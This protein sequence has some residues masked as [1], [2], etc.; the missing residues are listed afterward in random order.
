MT[1]LHDA[2]ATD[3]MSGIMHRGV[4]AESVV[5]FDGADDAV[6]TVNIEDDDA[7]AAIVMSESMLAL[8]EEGTA[9]YTVRP[10]SPP[11][12]TVRVVALRAVVEISFPCKVNY[13]STRNLDFT[14]NT[15][16]TGRTV[17]VTAFDDRRPGERHGADYACSDGQSELDRL[18]VGRRT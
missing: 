6:L 1:A 11:S 16:N 10:N 15:W 3:G 9:T 13:E 7:P 14:M 8:R 12:G 5:E 18:H 4:D 17:E 2:D